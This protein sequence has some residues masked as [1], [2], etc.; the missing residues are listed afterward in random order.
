MG[1]SDGEGSDEQVARFGRSEAQEL[2]F[3]FGDFVQDALD[4]EGGVLNFLF[5]VILLDPDEQA[6]FLFDHDTGG[7]DIPAALLLG[8]FGHYFALIDF[9]EQGHEFLESAAGLRNAEDLLHFVALVVVSEELHLPA[10][11]A[12]ALQDFLDVGEVPHV[13][14]RLRQLDVP[15]VALAFFGFSAG[16]AALAGFDDAESG[17]VDS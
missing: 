13:K 16:Q 1:R 3:F 9:G 10:V 5:F 8:V 12:D 11:V 7:D 2:C 14:N 4:F 6:H 15:K 17:V